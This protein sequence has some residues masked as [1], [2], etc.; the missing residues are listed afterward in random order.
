MKG[1]IGARV[2]RLERDKPNQKYPGIPD[3]VWENPNGFP[4]AELTDM[5]LSDWVR[6][7]DP[8]RDL[9]TDVT[10]ILAAMYLQAARAVSEA[11]KKATV[12][13]EGRILRRCAE[14]ALRDY[15]KAIRRDINAPWP[16]V[17]E[18]FVADLLKRAGYKPT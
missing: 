15:E 13:P 8:R 7:T 16:E 14:L 12:K 1:N 18:A 9:E 17:N 3:E 4:P 6:N 2:K 5:A 10:A 11:T